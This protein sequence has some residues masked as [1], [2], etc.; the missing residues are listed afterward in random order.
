[1]TFAVVNVP[2]GM[3]N[4]VLAAVNLVYGLYALMIAT[5]IGASS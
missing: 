3:G 5:P 1:L 2:Q 4:A